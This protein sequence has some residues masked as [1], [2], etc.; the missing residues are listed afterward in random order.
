MPKF[1]F[2]CACSL[3]LLAMLSAVGEAE[4]PPRLEIEKAEIAFTAGQGSGALSSGLKLENR[5]GGASDYA[6]VVRTLSGGAWLTADP[7]AVRLGAGE[8]AELNVMADPAGVPPGVHTGRISVEQSG[9]GVRVDVAVTLAVS[10][11]EAGAQTISTFAGTSWNFAAVG[12]PAAMAPLGPVFGLAAGPDG[13]YL[14]DAGNRMVFRLAPDGTLQHVAGNGEAGSGGDGGPA[15]SAQ[16]RYPFRVAVDRGGNVYIAD[17]DD[18]RVRRVGR[19]GIITTVAGTGQAGYAGDGGE[20]AGASLYWP[21]GVAVDGAG[22]LYIADTGNARIRKVTWDGF[23]ET[24]AGTGEAG[25]SVEGTPALE[26]LV[27]VEDVAVDTAGRVLFTNRYDGTV[28]AIGEGGV[29]VLAGSGQTGFAGDGEQAA[30]ARF[31]AYL[32]VAYGPGGE[33]YIADSGNGRVR[34]VS[35]SGEVRTVVGTGAAGFRGDDGPAGKAAL[36]YPYAVAVDGAGELWVADTYNFRVRRVAPDGTISTAAGSGGFRNAPEG[37]PAAQG[38]LTGPRGV[39]ADAAGNVY[40]ADTGGNRIRKVLPDGGMV[41]VAGTGMYGYF[42]D[43]GPAVEAAVAAPRAVAVDGE[44]NLYY[45]DGNSHTIRKI[46]AHGVIARFAGSYEASGFAGD[47]GQAADARLAGPEGLALDGLGNLYAADSANHRVRRIAPDG[48]IS[49][50]AGNGQAESTG[51]GGAAIEAGLNL[52]AG[53]AVDGAGN[54]YIAEFRG[55]RVR[56]VAPDG[57]ISTYAGDGS[58]GYGGDGGPAVEAALRDPYGLAVDPA[59]N[60]YIADANGAR[61]RKV[62]PDGVITTVAGKGESGFSGDGGPAADAAL[63]FP[64]GLA[65]DGA[66]RLF[67]ADSGNDRIRVVNPG[68]EEDSRPAPAVR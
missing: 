24:V 14:A 21:R 3:T 54:L 29:H 36:R 55:G 11:G 51:D 60:L 37:A 8:S 6:V 67:V 38:A 52:P 27:A 12:R 23:I 7:G 17:R 61:I 31:S 35:P 65:V 47:G 9:G 28:C 50:V 63:A 4:E 42:N 41:T 20:A 33:L 26:A 15:A 22:N 40:I 56:K 13:I 16:L 19:D 48:T 1:F 58:R 43:G 53:V 49:T 44:G 57:V 25:A 39:A 45:S 32:S 68:T 2:G 62:S 64:T 18:H 34:Q 30:A 10:A 59:G 46:D 5:G 66:G